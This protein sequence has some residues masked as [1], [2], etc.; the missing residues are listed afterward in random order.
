MEVQYSQGGVPVILV[1]SELLA[2]SPMCQQEEAATATVT[3]SSA[4][5]DLKRLPLVSYLAF[6]LIAC[7]ILGFEV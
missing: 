2:N 6:G 7:V 4:L 1:P 3:D 5:S